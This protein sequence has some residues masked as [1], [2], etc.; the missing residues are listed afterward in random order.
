MK[1]TGRTDIVSANSRVS[2]FL[3]R[4][5]SVVSMLLVV[6][7]LP[8]LSACSGGFKPLYG[9]LGANGTSVADSLRHVDI[10]PIPGRVGQRIRNELIFGTTGGDHALT[11][12]HRLEVAVRES[13]SSTLVERTGDSSS[14]VYNIDATFRLIE[15]STNKVVLEGKSFGRAGFER[16][17]SIFSNVRA[18]KDAE[19]RAARTVG[20]DLKG[21]IAVY[22]SSAA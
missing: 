9:S 16:F 19:D 10:A 17:S 1:N 8:L 14:R 4:R 18:R 6:L 15:L 13:V 3:S 12:T 20:G 11:P 22:L 2:G 21:Q 5:G 7:C